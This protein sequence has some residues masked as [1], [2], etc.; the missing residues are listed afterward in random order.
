MSTLSRPWP[1]WPAMDNKFVKRRQRGL[2]VLG[3]SLILIIGAVIYIGMQISGS[4]SSGSTNSADFEGTGNGVDQLVEDPRGLRR[5]PAGPELEEERG[6]VKTDGALPDRRRQQPRRRR[7]PAGHLPPA[8]GDEC[9]GGGPGAARP[10]QPRGDARH[11][12]RLH[13]ARRP[14]R[15]W[16]RPR[17]GV[18]SQISAVT[19][20]EGSAELHHRP[21]ARAG[22]RLRRPRGLGV[23][24][25]AR[26]P[27][28]PAATTPSA[29]RASSPRPVRGQPA[30]DAEGILTDLITRSANQF[31]ETG[32]VD[33]AGAIGPD[34]L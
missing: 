34:T 32:I 26:R 30:H 29:S 10:R 19:C 28:P 23:P 17:P 6:I 11:P 24:E 12:R 16:S 33:Q 31:N 4:G 18:Y 8:G 5:V 27:S 20:T 13:A 2:A 7:H 21:A 1:R 15:R 9:L 3:A 14:R 22:R 25:W